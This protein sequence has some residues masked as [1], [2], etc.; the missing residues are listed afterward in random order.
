MYLGWWQVHTMS[1]GVDLCWT[2]E[3][4]LALCTTK[5]FWDGQRTERVLRTT[6]Y[7]VQLVSFIVCPDRPV[8]DIGAY[9]EWVTLASC[10]GTSVNR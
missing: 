2:V 8:S 6:A 1:V 3:F 7:C 5:L 4:C 9:I 10:P